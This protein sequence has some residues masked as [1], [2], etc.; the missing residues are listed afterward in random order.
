MPTTQTS[1]LP[2][3]PLQTLLDTI[4]SQSRNATEKG[5]AFE[6]LCI[7]YLQNEPE[8]QHLY[9]HVQPYKEWAAQHGASLG[10]TA[11]D[12]GIDLVAT[13]HTG[14]HHAVQCKC[15]APDHI[16]AKP[17][18]DSFLS[19]SGHKAFSKRILIDTT[20]K[21]WGT[22]AEETLKH[23]S[24]PV[25]RID[26]PKLVNSR[27]DWS[28][29]RIGAPDAIPLKPRHQPHDYQ[30]KAI[31]DVLQGLQTA[32]RGKLIM[33]CGTGKT[34]TALKIAEAQAGA[35]KTVLFLVPSLALL[36]QTLTE[37]SQHSQTPITA[38]AV[39]S[40]SEVGK[41]KNQNSDDDTIPMAL[42][43]LAYPA[44]THAA[45]LA[46]EYLARHKPTAITVIFSTYHSID[47]ICQAQ[48]EHHLPAFDL[49]ICDEAHRTT[50]V[51]FD[52]DDE[53]AFVR[54]HDNSVIQ[55]TK[56][57][58]MTATPRIYSAGDGK[59]KR[60]A[61]QTG[62]LFASTTPEAAQTLQ[63]F[64]SRAVYSMDD[65][66]LYGKTLH[67]LGFAEAVRLGRLAPYKIIVLTIDE[68]DVG[69]RL[70][71]LLNDGNNNLQVGD[72][73]RIVG[74]Y[75]ALAKV[76]HDWDSEGQNRA[77]MQR[78]VAFCQIIGQD[79]KGQPIPP[80][81]KIAAR[82][83]AEQFN[84]VTSAYQENPRGDEAD[85]GIEFEARHIHG[86]MQASQKSELLNWLKAPTERNHCRVL[87][88]VRC[89]SEGVDVPALDA[90]IFL[91][92]RQSQVD[93]VQSIGRVMRK[94]PGKTRGYI[95]LP[96]VIPWG[97][98]AHEAMQDNKPWQVVWKT[99]AAL[100]AHDDEGFGRLIDRF[101]LAGG[102]PDHFQIS[103]DPASIRR[104]RQKTEEEQKKRG[105]SPFGV[106]IVR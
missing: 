53:S 27:I 102:D 22:N 1:Y 21:A 11:G 65:E 9:R 75:K 77:P 35:G 81:T 26:L 78:A 43:E 63:D 85:L 83:I 20:S 103:I 38:F 44:T 6:T 51:Q 19:A 41:H 12:K 60:N 56:R 4:R 97:M 55:A 48:K 106:G 72:A 49:A 13:T 30:Q 76:G 90:A 68:K 92:P 64:D 54:I 69:Q 25:I 86:G 34:F 40:D 36:S 18:I 99:L 57:L 50:G 17:D 73:A 101:E 71:K 93:I 37:W 14:E 95:I 74:C 98:T 5:T 52:G 61:Q 105:A 32:D 10:L 62:N 80:S 59:Q 3:S 16:V 67:T 24:I 70:Q 87:T 96:V 28:Q 33:A 31:D 79:R 58:Y 23:Q 100:K 8:Y 45:H 29:Y 7:R 88:N 47:V 46:K 84:L 66:R 94:A 15:Y 2:A 39:C 91:S 42:H 82:H 104:A 89:L